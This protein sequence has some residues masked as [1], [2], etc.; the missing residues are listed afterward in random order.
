[1]SSSVFTEYPSVDASG[2]DAAATDD[3]DHSQ[4]HHLMTGVSDSNLVVFI[5]KNG[6]VSVDQSALHDL[7]GTYG[8]RVRLLRDDR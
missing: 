2:A 5:N 6:S 8:P 4:H 3:A 1:M 7:L